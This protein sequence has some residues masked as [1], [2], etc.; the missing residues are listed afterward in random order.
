MKKF[1]IN[2]IWSFIFSKKKRKAFRTKHLQKKIIT[3]QT[4]NVENHNMEDL[5][6]TKNH[7]EI[8]P[9]DKKR[10]NLSI[11]GENNTI[12]IKKLN[13]TGSGYISIFIAGNN[14][15]IT[16]QEGILVSTGLTIIM[17]QIHPNFGPINKSSLNIGQDTY[18]GK[19]NI[20]TYNSNT[21]IEIGKNCM[22]SYDIDLFHSDGHPIYNLEKNKII[23]KVNSMKIGNHVWI[24]AKAI[25]LKN[26]I[27]PDNCIIGMASV[28]SPTTF[29]GEEGNCIAAGNPAKIRKRQITWDADGSQGYIQNELP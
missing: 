18:L 2:L 24:G 1:W 15:K 20:S 28:V 13:N 21:Q 25:I 16:L 5:M 3:P 9:E 23:N 7:I 29:K 4:S 14:C 11:Q 6:Y 10:V 12:I 17:G 27:I 22:F 26:T 8:E 19:C